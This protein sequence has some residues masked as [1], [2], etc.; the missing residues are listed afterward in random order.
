MENVEVE[1]VTTEEANADTATVNAKLRYFLKNGK[2]TPSSVRFSLLWDGENNRW[3][4][5]GAK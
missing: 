1:Q 3:V 4:V 2:Q 5:S